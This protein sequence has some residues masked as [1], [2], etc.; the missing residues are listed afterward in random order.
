[1]AAAWGWHAIFGMAIVPLLATL[2]LFVL[3]ARDSPNQPAPRSLADYSDVLRMRDTWWFCLLYS[4]TFGGFVGLASFLNVFFLASTAL[5]GSRRAI[6]PLS[7][8]S[9]ARSFVHW[10]LPCGSH[11]AEY[12]R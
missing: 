12:E 7:V 1:M 3:L 11:L 10:R 6:S 8:C 5:P 2:V 9:P 4:I